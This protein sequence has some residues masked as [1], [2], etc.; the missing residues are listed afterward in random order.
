MDVSVVGGTKL[1][2]RI[3]SFQILAMFRRTLFYCFLSVFL[4]SSLGMSVTE[5]T[6]FA[7]VPMIANVLFQMFLWGKV[8]DRLQRRRSLVIAGE[9]AAA[10]STVLVWYTHTLPS[11]PHTAGYVIIWGLTFVEVF[12]SM[13]NVAWSALLSDLYPAEERAGLQGRLLSIG[14]LGGMFGLWVGGAAYDGYARYYEGWGF[15]EGLLFFVAAGVMLISTIPMFF[16]PEG[17][18]RRSEHGATDPGSSGPRRDAEQS[19]L[20]LKQFRVFLAAMVCIQFGILGMA[21]IKPQYL[22]LDEGFDVSSR[23]LSYVLNMGAV[24]TFAVGLIV[25]P[26]SRRMRDE[27]LL[28]LGVA[29]ALIYLLGYALG[30]TLGAAFASELLYGAARVFVMSASYAYASRLIPPEKRGRQFALFNATFFL[31]WG[32]PGTFIMG[33]LIDGLIGSGMAQASAYRMGFVASAALVVTGA[34]ILAITARMA[35][36]ARG[37]ATTR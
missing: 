20:E 35:G 12:W 22:T 2:V 1:F 24:A 8:S 16:V 26:L 27:W 31:S 10:L 23:L 11:N 14:A 9:I 18:V 37:P 13:S 25:R 7:T 19:R 36:A 32:I 5:T 4:R 6:L 34:V 17:G 29:L 21:M 33:P 15:Q 28:F 30:S 3:S